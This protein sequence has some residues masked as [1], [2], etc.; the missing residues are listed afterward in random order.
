M[1][2]LADYYSFSV[3]PKTNYGIFDIIEVFINTC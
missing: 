1:A 3:V 2:V